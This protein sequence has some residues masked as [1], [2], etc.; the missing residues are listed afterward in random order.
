[1]KRLKKVHIILLIAVFLLIYPSARSSITSIT[2]TPPP[3]TIMST[4]LG[5]YLAGKTYTFTVNVIDPAAIGW[6]DHTM[7]RLVIPNSTALDVQINPTIPGVQAV[8]VNTG[9]ATV[10]ASIGG[11]GTV[12]NF[13]VTFLVTV[14][15]N[16]EESVWAP[17]RN[18]TASATSALPAANTLS[19]TQNVSYGVCSSI[20]INNFAMS[21][22]AADGYVNPWH[23]SFTITGAV[24][25]NIPGSTNNDK[26][27]NRT[28][29]EITLCELYEGASDLSALLP[30]AN[31][32]PDDIS[33]TNNA[34]DDIDFTV[35]A[36]FFNS[37]GLAL[38]SRTWVLYATMAN[39]GSPVFETV[40]LPSSITNNSVEVTDIE[41]INGGGN[42]LAGSPNRVYYRA[43][44]L[45]GAQ[46]RVTAQM[47]TGGGVIGNTT[48]RVSDGTNN[49][50]VVIANGTTIG[51]AN[52]V[53]YPTV[54]P[55]PL[56]SALPY[57]AIL[58]SGGICDNEQNIY[59]RI[60]QPGNILPGSNTVVN[61][62]NTDP[63]GTGSPFNG[64]AGFS[65]TQT[66]AAVNLTWTVL[67]NAFP[68]QD[69]DTYRI[70]Y[71]QNLSATW[72]M[73][74]RNTLPFVTY[75]TLGTIGT[76][77]FNI[78]GLAPLTDYDFRL[79][80]EDVFGN[81]VLLLDQP[82][83]TVAT[84]PSSITITLSDGITTYDDASFNGDPNPTT[85]PVRVSAIKI[86]LTIVTGGNTPTAVKLFVA[87]NNSDLA[88]QYGSTDSND[89]LT[90]LATGIL[91]TEKHEI[92][93]AKSGPNKWTAF[94]PQTD[95]LITS[96]R[97]VRF[98]VQTTYGAGSTYADHDSETPDGDYSN[99]EW[100]FLVITPTTFT[101]WPVR[102][103]N[104]VIT[105]SN[106]TAYPSYYLTADANVT[107][108][109]Y[110]IKG[111]SVVTLL[112]N[113]YRKGGQNIKDQGWSA[114]NKAGRNVGPGLYFIH[115]KAT[116]TSS[117][118]VILNKIKKIMV[119]R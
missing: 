11:A 115:I 90:S 31:S 61:W 101:P 70:Y 85:H 107:I 95:S 17:G 42:S 102:I 49:Y 54:L 84:L 77:S 51:I 57:Q 23:S 40:S 8:V 37:N 92:S 105:S 30:P 76:S 67:T 55:A 119:A 110:D 21:G 81:E 35:P 32:I 9:T 93:C 1:M 82:S 2:L 4:G 20:K 63:P 28:N 87:D 106:P 79:S 13:T 18:I 71:K 19:T 113:A 100:R 58:I 91:D 75:G 6:G 66:A 47:Q 78:T 96:G 41:I 38:G 89:D 5:Y 111:R 60:R 112:D 44:T 48:V 33:F 59:A 108:K 74:D 12:N 3:P 25:Y 16:T 86:E 65:S 118:A 10:T 27:N 68:D 36:E 69:F 97:I 52:M 50:D 34:V 116:S 24:L 88:A 46:V 117:G 26:V 114:I 73:I 99:R 45:P 64:A 22:V 80:A 103:L 94:I 43:T 83:F 14:N 15:W 39:G 62:D 53:T 56:T 29:N 109:I 98:I 104:N 72:L 7:V